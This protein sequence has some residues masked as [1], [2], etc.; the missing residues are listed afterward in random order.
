[1]PERP[2]PNI[3]AGAPELTE[4]A[5]RRAERPKTVVAEDSAQ[6]APDSEDQVQWPH[7]DG[8]LEKSSGHP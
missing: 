2:L 4:D 3:N 7:E 5:K 8:N 6:T 1:M